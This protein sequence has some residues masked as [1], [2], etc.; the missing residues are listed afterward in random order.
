MLC[1]YITKV[2]FNTSEGGFT[3][4]Y[5]VPFEGDL[6]NTYSIGD[7]VKITDKIKYVKFTDD[8]TG[9]TITYEIE[10]FEKTWTNKEDYFAT[11]GGA[12]PATCITKV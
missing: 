2:S 7:T 10:L 11:Q 1:I 9:D 8:S 12:L 6:T 5:N 4:S 3:G